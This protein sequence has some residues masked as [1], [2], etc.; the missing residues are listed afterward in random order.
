MEEWTAMNGDGV[1]CALIESIESLTKPPQPI[2]S[3]PL[4]VKRPSMLFIW[5]GSQP[6]SICACH[7]TH[8]MRFQSN[9]MPTDAQLFFARWNRARQPAGSVPHPPSAPARGQHAPLHL[10]HL[11]MGSIGRQAAPLCLDVTAPAYVASDQSSAIAHTSS[12]IALTHA[13]A[14]G[15]IASLTMRP[16]HPRQA[17]Q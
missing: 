2:R 1:G 12:V 14:K 16:L 3:M 9:E 5:W 10:V 11:C 7:R 13:H 15:S 17:G 8:P 6:Q 4:C